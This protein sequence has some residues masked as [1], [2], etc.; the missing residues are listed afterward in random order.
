MSKFENAY[1]LKTNDKIPPPHHIVRYLKP[2]NFELD[3][4]TGEIVVM[5][6]GFYP[7]D[8]DDALSVNWLEYY[9][10]N[11]NIQLNSLKKAPGMPYDKKAR[12]RLACF[13]ANDVREKLKKLSQDGFNPEIIYSPSEKTP[14]HASIINIPLRNA[15]LNSL[16]LFNL[17]L[18][19]AV[20]EFII[21]TP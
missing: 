20:L 14:S 2:T 10:E 3:L 15:E 16:K 13:I 7:R 11:R 17:C 18:S 5:H 19:E 8:K 6:D 12:G 21:A 9:G 4:I 1:N